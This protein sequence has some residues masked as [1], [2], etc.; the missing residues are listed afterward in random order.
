VKTRKKEKNT[1]KRAKK[2]TFRLFSGYFTAPGF[3]VDSAQQRFVS[4]PHSAKNPAFMT[5]C[6]YASG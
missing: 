2:P 3:F 4:P 6:T 1:L 5:P